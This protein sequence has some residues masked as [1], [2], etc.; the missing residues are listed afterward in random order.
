MTSYR[1]LAYGVVLG[2]SI[3]GC[4]RNEADKS[5][6]EYETEQAELSV[7]A[8]VNPPEFHSL[9]ATANIDDNFASTIEC[10]NPAL[11]GPS[12]APVSQAPTNVAEPITTVETRLVEPGSTDLE[13]N[14]LTEPVN[15]DDEAIV[16]DAL[17]TLGEERCESDSESEVECPPESQPSGQVQ[18]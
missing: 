7:L 18:F 16:R 9:A 6:L 12:C 8:P 14:I 5:A 10:A 3:S 4:G 17:F 2:L 11:G 13:Q 15:P 1:L